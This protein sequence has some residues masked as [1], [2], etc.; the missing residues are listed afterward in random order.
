MIIYK[1]LYHRWMYDT[2][3]RGSRTNR[4]ENSIASNLCIHRNSY[5]QIY[6]QVHEN[7][8]V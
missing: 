6:T 4:E 2:R 3:L 5:T 1:A 7:L 8:H